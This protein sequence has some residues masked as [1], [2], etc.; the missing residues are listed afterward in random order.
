MEY[1][2]FLI[3]SFLI[4]CLFQICQS[5]MCG[6]NQIDNC[7][8]CNL[9][10]C[11]LCNSLSFPGF[12][13]TKCIKCDDELHGIEGCLGNCKIE[14]KELKCSYCKSG[15]IY[16]EEICKNCSSIIPNCQNCILKNNQIRCVKCDDN[17]TLIDGKCGYIL[18]CETLKDEKSCKI[19]QKGYYL[20]NGLCYEC[21]YN[22]KN[23]L[24]YSYCIECQKNYYL[25]DKGRCYKCDSHCDE[26]LN[27]NQCKICQDGYYLNENQHCWSCYYKCLKCENSRDFCTECRNG[28]ATPKG[29]CLDYCSSYIYN[30]TTHEY[31]CSSCNTGYAL[32]PDGSC[33]KYYDGCLNFSYSEELKKVVCY[34]AA[35]G[36]YIKYDMPYI[37]SNPNSGCKKC[38]FEYTNF[39]CEEVQE[40]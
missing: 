15:Y 31:I 35:S 40:G 23:C 24:P 38:K 37:C 1:I 6:E 7:I 36:Y 25:S 2:I 20:S 5:L 22:C 28:L 30:K 26:C 33:V 21:D 14:N 29:K 4:Y 10:K 12:E 13:G 16:F 18:G 11:A 39:I 9:N 32:Y 19:C 17:Y 34:K 27:Q 3:K 8:I